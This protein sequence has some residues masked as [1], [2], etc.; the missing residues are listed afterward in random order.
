MIR[1]EGLQFAYG[2]K[3]VFDGFNAV[4]GPVAS[5]AGPSGCGKTTLLRLLAGLETPGGGSITGVPD[6]VAVMFQE[7][8]LLPWLTARQNVA[9]VLPKGND[10]MPLESGIDAEWLCRVALDDALDSY[11]DQLSGGQRR[12]VALARALAFRGGLLI[13]DEP[14]KGFDPELTRRMAA[15]ILAQNIPVV[16]ALHAPEEMALLGGDVVRLG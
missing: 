15:L 14:F 5:I 12:R 2:G 1:I 3:T 6:R 9:A 16:A 13:L 8:R 7:D 11:P 10:G 4:L